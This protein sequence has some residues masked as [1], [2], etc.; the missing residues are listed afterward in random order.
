MSSPPQAKRTSVRILI[1]AGLLEDSRK[2][3]LSLKKAMRGDRRIE[4]FGNPHM[5]H[6]WNLWNRER[7]GDLLVE[8]IKDDEQSIDQHLKFGGDFV[9]F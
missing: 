8:W 5:G 6:F 9:A 7:F 2:S 4:V 1:I 3:P